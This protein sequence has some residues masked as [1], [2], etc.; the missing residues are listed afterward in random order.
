[1]KNSKLHT[2]KRYISEIIKE[3]LKNK[4]QNPHN[5]VT[6]SPLRWRKDGPGCLE[7]TGNFNPS[8]CNYIDAN[9]T[10]T[11]NT[12]TSNTSQE[13]WNCNNG[14]CIKII[15]KGGIGQFATEQACMDSG[16]GELRPVGNRGRATMSERK[17][18][19]QKIIKKLKNTKGL[20]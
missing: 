3:Q 14:K 16:C 10:Q 13:S 19:V 20:K 2:V 12:S 18:L 6:S 1:M 11:S 15:G 4:L 17:Q 9:C 7:C 5:T 8:I